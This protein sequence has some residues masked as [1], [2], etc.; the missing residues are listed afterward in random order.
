MPEIQNQNSVAGQARPEQKHFKSFWPIVAIAVLAA[1][2]GGLVVY[3][4]FNNNL[5][6]DL[7]SLAPGSMRRRATTKGAYNETCAQVI[8][9]AKNLTSGESR[10]FPNSCLPEGWEALK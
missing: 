3:V 5:Q 7:N 6:E 9:P 10:N 1:V 2:V 4:V 8:T